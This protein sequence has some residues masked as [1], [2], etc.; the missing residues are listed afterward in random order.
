[1]FV[2]NS[3]GK[4]IAV[5]VHKP[6]NEELH[7]LAVLLPGFLDSKDYLH[8]VSL[9]EEL[10]KLGFTAVRFDPTGTW[11]SEGKISEYSV[12]Q[13]LRD[14]GSVISLMKKKAEFVQTVLIGHSLGG[15]IALLYAGRENDVDAVVAMTFPL[16]IAG[17][18]FW[19]D[20]MQE[21]ERV[22]YKASSRELPS[23]LQRTR[24]YTVPFSFVED[25][26][27]YAPQDAVEKI[28]VPLLVLAAEKDE[29]ILEDDLVKTYSKANEPKKYVRIKGATHRY[30]NKADPLK[31]VNEEIKKFFEEYS[32]V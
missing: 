26:M 19:K 32:L 9:G 10:S 25:S 18:V 13:Y 27:Q 5:G 7:S 16:T 11:E 31:K 28:H 17:T 8:L 30:W 24:E 14:V 6:Q 15:M 1:M 29:G 2:D 12:S 20:K 4:K 3:S 23:D 21:W 22:G